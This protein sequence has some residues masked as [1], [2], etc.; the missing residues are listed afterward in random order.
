MGS[1]RLVGD[2]IGGSSRYITDKGM[3]NGFDQRTL[4]KI[5]E[6]CIK[7]SQDR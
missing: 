3:L 4:N 5:E 2:R 7:P 6:A 1:I